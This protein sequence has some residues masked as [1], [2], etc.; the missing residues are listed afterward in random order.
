MK[1]IHDIIRIYSDWKSMF[2]IE[3]LFIYSFQM[4]IFPWSIGP[5]TATYS[6]IFASQKYV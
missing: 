5:Q 3:V 2:N 6:D 1:R 4:N